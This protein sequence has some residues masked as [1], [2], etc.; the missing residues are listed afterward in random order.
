[1]AA[2]GAQAKEIITKKILEIF[3]GAFIFDKL[4]RIPIEEDGEDVQIKVT[5]TAAK[6]NVD[7]GVTMATTPTEVNSELIPPSAEEMKMA[8]DFVKSMGF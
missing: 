7:G 1:M 4:I 8:E 3:N 2:R 6:D 5:L